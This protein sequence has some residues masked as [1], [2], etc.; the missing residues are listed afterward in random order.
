VPS[1]IQFKEPGMP[2][3]QTSRGAFGVARLS[4]KRPEALR[5]LFALG[6]TGSSRITVEVEVALQFA[7]CRLDKFGMRHRWQCEAGAQCGRLPQ[8]GRE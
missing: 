5:P 8:R 7:C 2:W 3:H 6:R 4:P 1:G